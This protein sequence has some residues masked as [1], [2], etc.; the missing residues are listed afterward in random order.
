MPF[1][2]PSFAAIQ[3]SILR[4][5]AN[6]LPDADTGADSDFAI[7]ANA[8]ASAIEGLY[9]HQAWMARQI[10]PDTADS[11]YLALHA[12]TRGLSK[13]PGVAASGTIQLT[14]QQTAAISG[15]LLAQTPD[16]RQYTITA[17]G[18]INAAQTI[19]LAAVAI[20]PG[21]AGNAAA[22][23]PV[24]LTQPPPGV[25]ANATIT[26]MVGGTDDETDADLLARLLDVIQRPPAGGNAADFRRWAMAVPGVTS[27]FVYP[28]RRGLGTCD[29]VITSAGGIPSAATLA[30]AQ[31]YIDSVRPVT[32]KSSLVLAPTPLPIDH[33]IQV[34]M[35]GGSELQALALIQ[36]A[37]A[38]YF[39][40]LPPGTPYVR[41]QV[42]TA[43]SNLPGITDRLLAAPTG[44]VVPATAPAVQWCQLGNLSVSLM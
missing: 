10:F 35:P 40:S 14:G 22:G 20:A 31:A 42:E 38:A 34:A 2:P 30:A 17:T 3:A 44:N 41:S 36:P 21:S 32:A 25:N 26:T 19:S 43:I 28:L 4:N 23:T 6:Q 8:T 13:K 39:A 11:D 7:R 15:P 33:V 27:A 18:A 37:L 9:Q 16:G 5:I 12:R 29:V 24:T 1:T